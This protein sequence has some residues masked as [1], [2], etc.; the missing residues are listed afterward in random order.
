M[1]LI[2]TAPNL[3]VETIV[4]IN[5]QYINITYTERPRLFQRL[6]LCL[7]LSLSLSLLQ[8]SQAAELAWYCDCPSCVLDLQ[9]LT[10][11]LRALSFSLKNSG[12]LA[13]QLL[14]L[15]LHHTYFEFDSFCFNL[16]PFVSF[17]FQCFFFIYFAATRTT[18]HHLQISVLVFLCL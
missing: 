14:H 2:H 3:S 9:T 8:I 6:C 1:F 5:R 4:G 18:Q 16:L 11:T 10:E 12:T 17:S 15:H 7:C 13:S